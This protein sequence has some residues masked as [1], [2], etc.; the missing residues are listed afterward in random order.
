MS[1][2]HLPPQN[3]KHSTTRPFLS[4]PDVIRERIYFFVLTPELDPQTPWITPLPIL[5]HTPKELPL[6]PPAPDCSLDSVSKS[7]RKKRRRRMR[8]YEKV[9]SDA[10]LAVQKA[11]PDTCLAILATCRTIL[12]EAFHIWYKHNTLNFTRAEDLIAFLLSLGRARQNEIR[13]IR[14]DLP[15]L[16]WDNNKAGFALGRL[17]RLESLIFVYNGFSASWMTH[18]RHIGFPKIINSLRGLRHVT[19]VNPDNPIIDVIG[20]TQGMS[21]SVRSRMEQLR[22]ALMSPP[23]RPKQAPPMIDLLNSLRFKD[24]RANDAKQ[25]VWNECLSYAPDVAIAEQ[26]VL[27]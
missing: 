2:L 1:R 21:A 11:A 6:L 12:L 22:Q 15:E 17:L 10:I 7:V 13:S 18:T 16:E 24:Q 19:F 14:L 9:K 25:W 23:K 3:V 27:E 4:L 26:R 5:R 8:A 20:Y